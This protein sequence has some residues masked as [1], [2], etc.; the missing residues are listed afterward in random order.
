MDMNQ[1]TAFGYSTGALTAIEF[2]RQSALVSKCLA[3]DTYFLP[4]SS[5][6]DSGTLKLT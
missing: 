1:L 5:E 6:I 2:A 3:F 4:L